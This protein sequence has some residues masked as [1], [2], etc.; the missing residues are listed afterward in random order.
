LARRPDRPSFGAVISNWRNYDAPLVEK[1]GLAATNYWRRIVRLR[2][3]CGNDGQP[4][5]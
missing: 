4:G 2:N 5:C 1:L 3:C